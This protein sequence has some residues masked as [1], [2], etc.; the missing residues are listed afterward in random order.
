MRKPPFST[1]E[2]VLHQVAN[3]VSKIIESEPFD[4]F[5]D[6]VRDRRTP[7]CFDTNAIGVDCDPFGFDG[8]LIEELGPIRISVG[9]F[10]RR[11]A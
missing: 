1:R 11:L 9:L 2:H 5:Q 3:V 4:E 8:V 10:L 6:K 7:F